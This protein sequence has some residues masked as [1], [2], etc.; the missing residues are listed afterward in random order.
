VNI[1]D[2]TTITKLKA[3]IEGL[4]VENQNIASIEIYDILTDAHANP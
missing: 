4:L 1:P 2:T 3:L